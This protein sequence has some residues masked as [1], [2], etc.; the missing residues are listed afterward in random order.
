[1][2]PDRLAELQALLG[3][4][5]VAEA[6]RVWDTIETARSPMQRFDWARRRVPNA[7]RARRRL[8]AGAAAARKFA[9]F[10]KTEPL[11][12]VL[13]ND[14]VFPFEHLLTDEERRAFVGAPG[15]LARRV[16]SVAEF[17]QVFAAPDRFQLAH[18]FLLGANQGA[19]STAALVLWPVL[20][21]LWTGVERRE[22]SPGEPLH[23]F[24]TLLHL[25]LARMNRELSPP[26]P[27]AGRTLSHTPNGPFHR[28]V[29]FVHRELELPAP[30]ASALRHAIDRYIANREQ[31]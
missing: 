12:A 21:D 10:L 4:A 17:A 13:L 6:R 1:L 15:R 20:F 16:E 27:G 9:A 28:F 5:D 26:A 18:L 14:G 22:P 31:K 7:Q 23:Q 2:T 3:T 8:T 30:S 11:A 25:E 19:T 24:F 29:K